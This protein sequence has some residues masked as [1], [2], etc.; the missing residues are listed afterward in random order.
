[1]FIK[2]NPFLMLF[3]DSGDAGG[4]ATNPPADNDPQDQEKG[5]ALGENGKKALTAERKARTAA[6]QKARELEDRIREFEDAQKSED[7]KRSERLAE[8]EKH[9]ATNAL[10]ALRYEV[11]A[12]R[13]LPLTAA[14]RLQGETKEEL[15]ADADELIALLG[16]QKNS[17]PRPDPSQG[18]RGPHMPDVQPGVPRLAQ[19]FETHLNRK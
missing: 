8:S 6:E 1:M 10:K 15:A 11:A 5:E 7:Q 16:E 3:T 18:S 13:G 4:A 19:A 14:G 12:E 9:A 17:T 2:R